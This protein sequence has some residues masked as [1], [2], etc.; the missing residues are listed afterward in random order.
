MQ[1][2]ANW[3]PG[4]SF[5]LS[6]HSSVESILSDRIDEHDYWGMYS[7]EFWWT[8]ESS[9]FKMDCDV[10]RL[11][12]F[13]DTPRCDGIG[14]VYCADSPNVSTPLNHPFSISEGHFQ[15]SLKR[16]GIPDL[17]ERGTGYSI[18]TTSEDSQL[19]LQGQQLRMAEQAQIKCKYD[20]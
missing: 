11:I 14:V 16:S 4:N 18:T 20:S 6:G 10:C 15:P 5:C 3:S 9:D 19:P 1:Q 7:K 17:R 13:Q 8:V 2:L 12:W